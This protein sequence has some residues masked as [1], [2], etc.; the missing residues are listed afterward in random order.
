MSRKLDLSALA[1][2]AESGNNSSVKRIETLNINIDDL[3]LEE[4]FN[5]FSAGQGLDFS[6][7]PGPFASVQPMPVIN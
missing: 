3:L 6:P 1:A 4:P 5:L 2:K 7:H